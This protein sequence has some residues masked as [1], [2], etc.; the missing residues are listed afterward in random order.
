MTH[1]ALLL[2]ESQVRTFINLEPLF[3]LTVLGWLMVALLTFAAIAFIL[4]LYIWD[5][6]ELPA[7]ITGTLMMLRLAAVA[8]MLVFLINPA[9][10]TEKEIVKNSRVSVLVDTSLS[11]ALRDAGSTSVPAPPSRIEQVVSELVNGD[12]IR[13][14]RAK[15][16]VVLYRF[17]QDPKPVPIASFPKLV[18]AS[19]DD[20]AALGSASEQ[21]LN[22]SRGIAMVGGIAFAVACILGLSTLVV[23]FGMSLGSFASW[24]LFTTVGTLLVAVTIIAVADMWT[25]DAP[26]L[27]I[28]G[29]SANRPATDSDEPAEEAEA[30]GESA[31][32]ATTTEDWQT[33]LLP[34]GTATRLG[35]AIRYVVNKERGGPVAGL[36]VFTDGRNNTGLAHGAAL[37]PARDAGIPIHLVGMGSKTR[38]ANVRVVDLEAPRRVY[39]GD[40]FTIKGLMQSY[41][42]AG[43]RVKIRL[44]STSEGDPNQ[45]ERMEHEGTVNLGEDGREIASEFEID[46][47]DTDGK[48][49][50]KLQVFPPEQDLD[51][52]DNTKKA[53]VEVVD[54]KNRVLLMAGGPTREYRFLR[55]QLFRDSAV[56]SHVFLQSGLADSSQESDELLTDFPSSEDEMFEYDCVLAFDPDWRVLSEEQVDLLERW[57][58]EKAGGLI[59]VAG[60]VFTPQWTRRPRGEKRFDTLRTLYPVSFFNQGSA[61]IKLGRFGGEEAWPLDFTREGRSVDFLWLEDSNEKSREAWDSFEGVYGYYA[62]NESKPGASVYARFS[63]PATGGGPNDDLPIYLAGQFYGAGRVFFQASGEMWRIRAVDENYFE[64]YYTK[65]I[66]WASQG[67]LLRD[68]SRGVLLIDKDRCL[69]GDHIEVRAMLT[70]AQHLPLVEDEVIA[71]V[72]QP[73]STRVNLTLP[74]VKDGTREGTFAGQFTALQEGDYEIVVAIP[75]SDVG[76]LLTRQVGVRIPDLEIELPQRN[77]ALLT[78][79][80]EKTGGRAFFGIDHAMNRGGGGTSL[81]AVIEPQDQATYLPGTPNERFTEKL[82]GWLLALICGVLSLEWLIRRLSKLA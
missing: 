80:A 24:M 51:A 56:E 58:A 82:M 37:A 57:V 29:L 46:P 39:P 68:S 67:R 26:L 3:P 6:V 59:V 77:D 81:A 2:A 79:V 23:R 69:L 76:E 71:V 38:P 62:V 35:D 60:P 8:G 4:T 21:S 53:T 54:R 5:G 66:R 18:E 9:I 7:G 10:R 49:I 30:E 12:L 64:Q 27:S 61:T 78:E 14:L 72:I 47:E 25:P 75:D 17:D 42:L 28:V 33:E 44:V 55:N 11:M 43:R 1:H 70:D 65:L 32:L 22:A 74:R 73:D 52:R 40:K 36:V 13:Q 41:G 31:D 16:D 15:H 48:R 45:A 50:Y 19:A 63:D 20:L 34:Q